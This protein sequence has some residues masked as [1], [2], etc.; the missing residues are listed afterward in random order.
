MFNPKTLHP[1]LTFDTA[2]SGG[3]GGQNVNKVETKVE[4]RLDVK[5]S[6]LLTDSEKVVLLEKLANKIT[7]EGILV[8]YHQT[9]RTQLGNREK[10]VKKF[11]K[12][13]A[14]CFV[15]A[16]KRKPMKPTAAMVAKRLSTKQR[17][18]ELK[19][20]RKRVEP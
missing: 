10:I 16:K 15:E 19:I 8:L 4:L 12:L 20:L 1:E 2:R 11:D 18:S 3:A 9:E 14:A 13:V 17:N 7:I 5:N 6:K